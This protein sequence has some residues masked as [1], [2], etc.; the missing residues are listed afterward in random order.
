MKQ[1]PSS[2][3]TFWLALML[4]G[5]LCCAV[6]VQAQSVD[7][8]DAD[9]GTPGK[10]ET[11]PAGTVLAVRLV[12]ANE[13]RPTTGVLLTADGLVAVPERFAEDK[14]ELLVLDGGGNVVRNGRRATVLHR[15][16]NI[17]LAVLKVEGLTGKPLVLAEAPGDDG[18]ALNFGAFPPAEQMAAGM[19]PMWLN[20]QLSANPE[21]GVFGLQ[22]ERSIPNVSGPLFN[23]CEQWVGYAIATGEPQLKSPFG[24]ITLFSPQLRRGLEALGIKLE[25]GRCDREPATVDSTAP[26]ESSEQE[27]DEPVPAETR[28][29]D[30]PSDEAVSETEP[31]VEGSP[32]GQGDESGRDAAAHSFIS[33][34][35]TWIWP[36]LAM[37]VLGLIGL[38]YRHR[39]RKESAGSIDGATNQDTNDLRSGRPLSSAGL[40]QA[41]PEAN[42]LSAEFDAYLQLQGESAD[43][44]AMR[45]NVPVNKQSFAVKVTRHDQGL[46]AVSDQQHSAGS[47]DL[48][49]PDLKIESAAGTLLMTALESAHPV[50][51]DGMFCCAGEQFHLHHGAIIMLGK[52]RFDAQLM[53]LDRA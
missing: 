8:G 41:V 30:L 4:V 37:A 52:T 48:R 39:Q 43:G 5:C 29:A 50:Y 42:E 20:I 40:F 14:T 27:T 9:S 15:S 35:K 34:L 22:G 45:L 17:G 33:S 24:P 16:S 11:L 53:P 7:P 28:E 32:D 46:M 18:D 13:V 6:A 21:A 49:P 25:S 2:N 38:F 31:L 3:Q 10:R 1:L 44:A 12:S 51:I 36:L 47:S 26:V 19:G 23:R